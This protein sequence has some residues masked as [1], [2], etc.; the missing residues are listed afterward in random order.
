M[1]V[2]HLFQVLVLGSFLAIIAEWH[3]LLGVMWVFGGITFFAAFLHTVVDRWM[4][5]VTRT[6]NDDIDGPA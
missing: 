4:L 1:T 6:P 3:A 5:G 2:K